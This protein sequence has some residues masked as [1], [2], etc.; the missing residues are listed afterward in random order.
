M[1]L[2]RSRLLMDIKPFI[3]RWL[4]QARDG[5]LLYTAGA[6]IRITGEE[7]SRAGTGVLLFS[8]S[9]ALLA[10]YARTLAGLQA[11]L[12][13]ASSGD[14][15][16]LPEGTITGWVNVPT[17][18]TLR[19][20]GWDSIISGNLYQQ[21]SSRAEHLQVH[22]TASGA[23]DQVAWQLCAGA[24][25]IHVY[26]RVTHTGTGTALAAL[27]LA[28]A[29]EDPAVCYDCVADAVGSGGGSAWGGAGV[30]DG[31]LQWHQGSV[32]GRES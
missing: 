24:V 16:E 4:Q 18:V 32:Q 22:A 9:G 11:A 5:G 15:V 14:V 28:A 29:L 19:G 3:L 17:G 30:V 8:G 10:E 13:A 31:S 27:G 20:R 12:A 21:A 2:K 23:D 26:A 6:D 1:S 25:G 7:V